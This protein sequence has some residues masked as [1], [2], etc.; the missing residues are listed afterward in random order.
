MKNAQT[1]SASNPEDPKT[2]PKIDKSY[3]GSELIRDDSAGSDD[4]CY[5]PFYWNNPNYNIPDECKLY[6]K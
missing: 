1:V 6:P 4:D 2:T 5:R 3:D